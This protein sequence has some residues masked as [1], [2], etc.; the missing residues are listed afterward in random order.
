LASTPSLSLSSSS[1][2]NGSFLPLQW[3]QHEE[4]ILEDRLTYRI[5][6]GNY[7]AVVSVQDK[8]DDVLLCE[9]D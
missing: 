1:S 5:V 8:G 2:V 9:M 7:F 3:H 6:I 4:S